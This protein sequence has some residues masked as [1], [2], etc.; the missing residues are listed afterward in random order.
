[1]DLEQEGEGRR[2]G[3]QKAETKGKSSKATRE[4]LPLW[5]DGEADRYIGIQVNILS[6]TK[7]GMQAD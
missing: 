5:T 1:M 3:L 4:R 2:G 7:K 6:G